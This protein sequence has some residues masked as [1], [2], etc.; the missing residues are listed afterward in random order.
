MLFRSIDVLVKDGFWINSKNIEDGFA[1]VV[2]LTGL[3][4]RWQTLS[5]S[6]RIVCD[7]AHNVA[8]IKQ[9]LKNLKMTKYHQLWMILG[10]V[11]DKDVSSILSLLPKN[12]N[13]IFCQANI[14]RALPANELMEQALS[15]G[16][17]GEVIL[18]VNVAIKK[19]IQDCDKNDF[20]YVGGSTF[21][22]AEI[23]N[24]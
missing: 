11:S 8:G 6:P 5:N 4:G 12:A 9:I 14:P 22:V 2:D 20:V 17:H 13:Y 10:F 7:T 1:Q 15:F 24:L 21:V 3:K 19:V 18:N 16:L 23:D